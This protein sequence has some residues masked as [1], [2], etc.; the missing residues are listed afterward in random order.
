LAL[1]PLFR[2]KKIILF[3]L[4][5]F[6]LFW[7]A[8]VVSWHY[9]FSR[10]LQ[11][12]LQPSLL[13]F[14]HPPFPQ[15]EKAS[16]PVLSAKNYLLLDVATNTSLLELNSR[17]KIYPASITKLAT[18]LT[19]LNIYPLDE[20]VVVPEVYDEGKVMD[21]AIGEK[22]TVRSLV[23]ALLVY[24]ANDAAYNLAAHHPDG[25]SGFINQMNLLV[26]KYRLE[27][28]HFVNFDGIH[29]PDHYSSV[30]D[31]AQI[32]RLAIKNS[33]VR[34]I[35]KSQK[36]VVTD[37]DNLYRHELTST[38]ELLGVIP[39]VQGLKT[40]Y[41]LEAG[42]CFIGLLNFA[43][44]EVISVVAQS[45]DRFTDTRALIDWA[46]QHLYWTSFQP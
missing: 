14:V 5:L 35:V 3:A 15:A 40:G 4:F 11:R 26:K 13:D 30:Y 18:A 24:S 23:S 25:V 38:N 46:R 28:T 36:I 16:P 29:H 12:R 8:M 43:D 7:S 42:G 39:E 41:T 19:A 1:L 27:N 2:P 31:L 37:I 32:G 20:I 6:S 21:L 45:P 34:D 33:I 22:L 10:T 17:E 44:H 9:P